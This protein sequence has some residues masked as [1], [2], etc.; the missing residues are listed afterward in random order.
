MW[1]YK[2]RSAGNLLAQVRY[3]WLRDTLNSYFEA[4]R[5]LPSCSYQS[6]AQPGINHL[7]LAANFCIL[8]IESLLYL[9]IVCITLTLDHIIKRQGYMHLS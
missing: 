5:D 7:A 8:A 2:E 6:T 9:A 3:K 1:R 4:T